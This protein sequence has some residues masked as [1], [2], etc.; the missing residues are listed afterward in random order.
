MARAIHPGG[1]ILNGME[2]GHPRMREVAYELGRSGRGGN[3]PRRGGWRVTRRFHS[4][5]AAS[6]SR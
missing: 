3:G 4:V 2:I 6:Q 5:R 1:A